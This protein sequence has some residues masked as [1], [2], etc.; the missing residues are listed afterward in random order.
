MS[1]EM[2]IP[3]GQTVFEAADDSASDR[4]RLQKDPLQALAGLMP[5]T[6]RALTEGNTGDAWQSKLNCVMGQVSRLHPDTVYTRDEVTEL[7]RLLSR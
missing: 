3:R 7:L 6:A 2:E 1:E 4:I 5:Q